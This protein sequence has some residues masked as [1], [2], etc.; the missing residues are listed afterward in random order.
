MSTLDSLEATLF[1]HV[2][3]LDVFAADA[4]A[5]PNVHFEP[6]VGVPYLRVDHLPNSNERYFVSSSSA[7]LFRGILQLTVVAPLVGGPTQATALA[8]LVADWFPTDLDLFSGDGLKIRI[9]RY[10]DLAPAIMDGKSWRAP[11][12]VRYECSGEP[13]LDALFAAIDAVHVAVVGMLG[14][15]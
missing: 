8:A 12:S 7:M 6:T 3:D 4:K 10:P 2:R 9:E 15:A 13:S 1:A 14:E 11:V 5:W